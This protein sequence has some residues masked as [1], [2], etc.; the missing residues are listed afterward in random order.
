MAIYGFSQMPET[1]QL[2]PS[3]AEQL[4]HWRWPSRADDH[5]DPEP[6]M[7]LAVGTVIPSTWEVHGPRRPWMAM[8]QT[9]GPSSKIAEPQ[10]LSHY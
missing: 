9:E 4:G 1:G 2:Q 5:R 10:P 3:L 6:K 8:G 7:C